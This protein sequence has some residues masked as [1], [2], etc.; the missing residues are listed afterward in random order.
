MSK[1]ITNK[2]NPNSIINLDEIVKEMGDNHRSYI[3]FW[4]GYTGSK[5]NFSE[6]GNRDE[7]FENIKRLGEMCRSVYIC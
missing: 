2:N 3:Y 6:E 1:Y 4:T 7:V 5:Y